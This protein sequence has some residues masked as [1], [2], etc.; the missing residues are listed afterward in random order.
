VNRARSIRGARLC[1]E[2]RGAPAAAIVCLV[3]GVVCL[4]P[5]YA[6]AQTPQRPARSA[7]QSDAPQ[8]R[9]DESLIMNVPATA[10]WTDTGVTLQTGDRLE[11]RAWGSASYGDVN[12]EGRVGPNGGGRGGTCSFVVI[13]ERAPSH[14]LVANIAPRLTF[15]GRGFFVGSAWRGTI[16]VPGGTAPEGRL[17]LGFNHPAVLCDRS[18]YDSW[19]FRSSNSGAFTVEIAIRRRR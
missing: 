14:A 2:R 16:P 7:P 3:G 13:D 10:P 18:G 5:L 17:F 1:R 19:A 6:G 15:D 9:P 11:I 4:A 8:N 12:H